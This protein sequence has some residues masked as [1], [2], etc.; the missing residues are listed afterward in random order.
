MKK[1]I[2]LFFCLFNF[3]SITKAFLGEDLWL[4]LYKN[5]NNWINELE[6]KQYEYELKW[7]Q[8]S[9]KDNFNS[10]LKTYWYSE[11][12]KNE[13]SIDEIN[14]ISNWNIEILYNN[15]SPDCLDD[16]KNISN[17]QINNLQKII[18]NVNELTIKKAIK[19]S[20]NINNISK[21]W[22]YADW[23][24]E[25]AP[26]DLIKDLQDIDYYIFTEEI[27][28]FWETFQNND[29]LI[30]SVLWINSNNNSI[31]Q[32]WEISNLNKANYNWNQINNNQNI[33]NNWNNNSNANNNLNNDVDC[34]DEIKN[35]ELSW[36]DINEVKNLLW[37]NS[38]T[39]N[40]NSNTWNLNNSNNTNNLN[41]N[42]WIIN[43]NSWNYK[44]INDN[45]VYPCSSFFCI[46]IE[47]LTY[48][49][50]LLWWWNNV[51]IEYLV[52][53]SNK[54]LKK[55]AATSLIQAEMTS[56]NW[57][58]WLK[59]LNLADIFH[60]WFIITK[61]PV[62][63]LD[64][65]KEEKEDNTEFSKENLLE[66]YYKNFWLEYKRRNDIN[67]FN[68]RYD[69]L[70]IVLDLAELSNSN[71]TQKTSELNEVNKQKLNKNDIV[72]KALFKKIWNEQLSDF[73]NRFIELSNFTT[74]IYNYVENIEKAIKFMNKIK[75]DKW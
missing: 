43:N 46:S 66:E 36:L 23:I 3:S 64:L 68:W 72:N 26:F 57:E 69:E 5:I 60:V 31:F 18:K 20:E 39:N 28:Y 65:V 12:I 56:N 51:S 58:L 35:S 1:L 15:I 53:R 38:N 40:F 30:D 44:K 61:K 11:C 21:I 75:I 41:S 47:F 17:T 63:I 33:L 32:N 10:I 70:K 9:I 16:D 4:N 27:P 55:F 7:Q 19:K 34:I 2:L 45:S 25:N 50:N 52:N 14:K 54:H 29:E 22:I 8:G 59:D 42:T 71:I 37:N 24:S 49:H 67:N 6:F 74:S 13:P 73:E 48:Q 62:P